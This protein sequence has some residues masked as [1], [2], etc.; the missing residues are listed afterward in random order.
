[1]KRLLLIGGVLALAA[2]GCSRRPAPPATPPGTATGSA[3]VEVSGGK[4]VTQ[5]GM[6]LD[7]PVAVQVNDA[8]GNGVAGAEVVLQG[9]P[10]ARFA[11]DLGLTDSSGQFS[12]VVTLGGL[13]GR[14]QI[15]ATTKNK[16]GQT[17][18]LVLDEIALG[19]QQTLGRELY[20]Q[21]CDR[22]H[23]PESSAQR[24]S[25]FDNLVAKPHPFTEGESLNKFTD[26]DLVS[27]I[28]HGG[29]ALGKSA[30]M[31]AYGYTLSQRDIQALISYIRAVSNPPY[32][33][34][35]LVYARVDCP[36]NQ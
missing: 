6:T 25:N 30:E 13:A 32:G 2:V 7:Q 16:D 11:P 29:P 33:A 9:P 3:L 18:R 28:G 12:S 26:A 20:R 31:P 22:C 8:A 36:R 5:A 1:M 14:Y 19:Y 23:D 27:I 21:Y 4:Q 10:G 24:V 35:G 34:K 17:I 15:T